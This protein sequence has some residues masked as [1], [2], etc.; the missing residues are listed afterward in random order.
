MNLGIFLSP[1]ESFNL[2]KQTG[3][4]MRFVEYY[5]KNYA[6]NFERVYVFS[7]LDESL[8]LPS[9]VILVPNKTKLHRLIYALF[10]PLICREEVNKCDVIRGFGLASSLSSFLLSKPF[11]F[12]WAYDYMQF[13]TIEKR[14]FYIPL[15]FLLEKL[16]F[17][18]A[19]YIFIAT[20]SKIKKLSGKKFIYLPNGVDLKLFKP[21]KNHNKKLAFV[22]RLEKPKNL[23]FLISAVSLLPKKFRSITFIGSGSQGRDLKE[24]A[25]VKGVALKIMSPVSNVRLPKL[26]GKF[27]ILTLP[28]LAE[29][30]PKVL[31][32][33]MA[34]GIVPVVTRFPTAEEVIKDSVDGYVTEYNQEEYANKIKIL[35]SNQRLFRKMSRRS[36]LKIT[37]EF[38]LNKLLKKEINILNY[39]Q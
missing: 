16:A 14:F 22:G 39:G 7:Y 13:A 25:A 26:L 21:R 8:K 5:L 28:S 38:D 1:G 15:Y 37:K 3:Q 27:S 2:M 33:A 32:E 9:K 29:G 19:K 12:N 34:C 18:K 35:L 10:L 30:S 31:L 36:Y 4:D 11:I 6:K 24:H 23:F 20:K 17:L